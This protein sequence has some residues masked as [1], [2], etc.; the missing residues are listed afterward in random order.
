MSDQPVDVALRFV[1]DFQPGLHRVPAG[2]GFI[3]LDED[4]A[5]VEDPIV[6]ERIRGLAIPPAWSAVWIAPSSDAHLQATGVD[7]R[8]RKQYRYHPAWRHERDQVKFRDMEAFGRA[9]RSLRRRI[10]LGLDDGAQPLGHRRVLSLSL[11]L[12]DIGLLR[13]GSDRYAHDNNHYGLTTLLREQVTVRADRAVFDYVGKAGKRHRLAI[14]DA[15]ALEVLA[16]LKRRRRDPRELL[17]FRA[18][19]GWTRIHREDV[20]N[21]LRA[22][23]GGPF[24][25]KEYRT[26]NA[27]VIAA[28]TLAALRPPSSRAAAVASRAVAAALGNTPTVARQ[29]YID[30]R[31]LERFDAGGVIALDRLPSDPWQ[32]RTRIERR[33]LAMLSA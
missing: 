14:A 24:S 16:A 18:A 15:P 2:G 1:H 30:P 17:V 13:V 7:S 25:A 3:Y 11:R 4:G 31:V 19:H 6:L 8:G 22:E 10:E 32:A 23:S 29:S 9:Q 20:N 5:L 27:T 21:F 28:A 26:W 12:L 33:V